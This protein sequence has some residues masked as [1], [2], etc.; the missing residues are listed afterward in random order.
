MLASTHQHRLSL[1]AAL[2]ALLIVLLLLLLQ[3]Q[4]RYS[5]HSRP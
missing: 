3:F 5:L 2:Q 4:Q 1:Q